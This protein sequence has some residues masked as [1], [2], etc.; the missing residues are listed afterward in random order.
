[1]HDLRHRHEHQVNAHAQKIQSHIASIG[2]K[3][4][5]RLNIQALH[6]F[7]GTD[8][9]SNRQHDIEGNDVFEPCAASSRWP[10][11]PLGFAGVPSEHDLHALFSEAIRSM[12]QS[13]QQLCDDPSEY[14][15]YSYPGDTHSRK[16]ADRDHVKTR[17]GSQLTGLKRRASMK[18]DVEKC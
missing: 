6:S 5:Q 2:S 9:A 14:A 3:L 18:R 17:L 10:R 11:T 13:T 16:F 1:M 15:E 12:Q 8:D 7:S 4:S